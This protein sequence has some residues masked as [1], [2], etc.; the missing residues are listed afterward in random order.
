MLRDCLPG[1]ALC[2]LAAV[3]Q[4]T[5]LS[6]AQEMEAVLLGN[7]AGRPTA[8]AFA[9]GVDDQFYVAEKGG[10]I[11]IFR[12]GNYVPTPFLDIRSIVHNPG[13]SGLLGF[14]FDPDFQTNGYFYVAYTTNGNQGDSMLSRFSIQPGNVNAADPNSEQIIWGPITQL[15]SGH[16]AGDLEFG[17]DGMLYHA[18]GD[19]DGGSAN[20]LGTAQ[21]LSDPRGKILRFDVRLPY[22]HIP[23][24][25]PYV[26]S[27]S[28]DGRIWASGFR[29][30]YRID[31]DPVTGDVYVG[32]V[33]S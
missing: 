15:S 21:D 6:S 4:L 19:G 2:S 25:N 11:F 28:A 3:L 24:D 29:N 31:I 16:K 12:N 23:P 17:P 20:N 7:S 10:R 1:L 14:I 13:E 8:M 30:P 9:P 26:N 27:P 5:P 22:P 18:L 33:G 32:D